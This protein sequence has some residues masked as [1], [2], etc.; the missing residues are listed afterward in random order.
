MKEF[1]IGDLTLITG[2]VPAKGFMLQKPV[3]G[4]ESP[5]HR[6]TSYSLPGRNGVSVSSKFLDGRLVELTGTIR[7]TAGETAAEYEARRQAFI[8]AITNETGNNGLPIPVRI[9]FRTLAGQRYYLDAYFNDPIM[10]LEQPM[11][12]RF[13]VT[14]IGNLIY[15]DDTVTSGNISRPSGGGFLIPFNIPFTVDASTGGTMILSNVGT[16]TS[17]PTIDEAGNGGIILTG[18]LHNPIISNLTTGQYIELNYTIGAGDYVQIDMMNQLILLNGSS[19]LIHAKTITSD[20]WGLVPGPNS[21]SIST[22]SA[23]DGGYATVTFN[24]AFVGI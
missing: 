17:Y 4:L 7:A 3:K 6:T 5:K 8:A 24:P 22:S 10:P 1:R 2:S 20:W 15:G 11:S 13:M 18:E 16:A 14:A 23:S 19:S 21:V 12:T 9:S